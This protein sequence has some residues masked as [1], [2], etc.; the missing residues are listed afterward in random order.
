MPG[1]A[2]YKGAIKLSGFSAFPNLPLMKRGED[3]TSPVHQT[4]ILQ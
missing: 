4:E 1:S 3:D 2:L